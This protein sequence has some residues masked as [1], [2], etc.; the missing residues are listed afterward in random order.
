L[1]ATLI[2]FPKAG[3]DQSISVTLTVEGDGE[4]WIRS[5]GG[6][7]FSS[8]QHLGRGRSEWLVRERFGPVCVD[9]ALVVDGANL[10]YIVRRWALL[11]IPLPLSLGP[12]SAAIESA[13]DGRF[14]FQVEIGHPFTGLIVRYCGLLTATV[15]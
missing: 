12:R 10:R 2:G 11:G 14:R 13:Q 3:S 15:A 1:V 7:T 8:V 6:R 4:R 9:M 5:S